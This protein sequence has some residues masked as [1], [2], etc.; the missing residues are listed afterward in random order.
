[1]RF[2]N[3]FVVGFYLYL[4]TKENFTVIQFAL[5]KYFC[6]KKCHKNFVQKFATENG[7]K[8]ATL[9]KKR[10]ENEHWDLGTRFSQ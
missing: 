1:M 4:R 9:Q 5:N 8:N 7:T 2:S 10:N 6:G 3:I